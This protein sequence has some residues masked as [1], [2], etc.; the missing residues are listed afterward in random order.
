M[1]KL[2]VGAALAVSMLAA[3][4]AANAAQYINLTAPAADGSITG[5][6]GDT[7]VAGGDFSHVFDFIFPTNGAG[8]A[9]ISS[10]LTLGAPSTN[11]NFT[12][13]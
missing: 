7:A 10:I 5:M 3:A 12:S 4:P 2:F 6:F 1:K 11:I 13:V 8:G 9:T